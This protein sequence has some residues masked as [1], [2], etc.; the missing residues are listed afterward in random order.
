MSFQI[1]FKPVAVYGVGVEITY[2]PGSHFLLD[3][4]LW[5]RRLIVGWRND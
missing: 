2:A 3:A 5:N 4:L 1:V